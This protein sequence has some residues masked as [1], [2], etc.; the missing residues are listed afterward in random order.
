MVDRIVPATTDADRAEIE[1]LLG[2]R[3]E[4]A[5]VTEPFSQWVIEDR[6]KGPRPAWESH[7]AQITSDVHAYENAKLRMLNGA[8]SA[9][10]YL[11]LQRGYEFV[12][13]AIADADLAPLIDRLMREE[14]AS[15]L[16]PAAGQD[17]TAYADALIARFANPALNHRLAQIAM[18]GSQKIPQRW[19][20]TLAFHQR[21]DR[22]CEAILSGIAAWIRHIRGDNGAVDDPMA[23]TLKA[24]CDAAGENGIVT[25]LFGPHGP[26]ASDWVPSGADRQ[27]IINA[28]NS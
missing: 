2:M 1:A 21:Q 25:A 28:L 5:V 4:A 6:F 22:Q 10:A 14:A 3:D 26:M 16:T 17:L 8:H 9:L 20:E 13:Q 15:S 19:L 23:V 12:H 18:D 11:G 27:T 7:G 24:T